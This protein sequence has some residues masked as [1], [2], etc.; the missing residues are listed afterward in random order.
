MSGLMIDRGDGTAISVQGARAQAEAERLRQL[1]IAKMETRWLC[2]NASAN[3]EF[4]Q[5]AA[6]FYDRFFGAISP[7]YGVT[8]AVMEHYG[9]LTK[10]QRDMLVAHT[11][12]DQRAAA[13][14]LVAGIAVGMWIQSGWKAGSAAFKLGTRYHFW[15]PG[16]D[17]SM[18][19]VDASRVS[20]T[21][22]LFNAY[23]KVGKFEKFIS[24]SNANVFG[25]CKGIVGQMAGQVRAAVERS[26]R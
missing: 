18:L 6:I 11:P 23:F 3:A 13:A 7:M 4:W 12:G 10:D 19:A 24:L 9:Y 5:H 14:G 26:Q 16:A 1:E 17:F 20:K 22:G 2:E 21:Y 25:V 15:T 8:V